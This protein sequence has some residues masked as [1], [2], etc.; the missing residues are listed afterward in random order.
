MPHGE[1]TLDEQTR[2]SQEVIDLLRKLSIV[3]N[4]AASPR[5]T[6]YAALDVIGRHMGWLL[7]RVQ[8]QPIGI[9]DEDLTVIWFN[10]SLVSESP[11]SEEWPEMPL[12]KGPNGRPIFIEDLNTD[13][14]WG[15]A[16]PPCDPPLRGYVAF[17]VQVATQWAGVMEF[18]CDHSTHI[19]LELKQVLGHAA[20]L[21]GLV[22]E[23][24]RAQTLMRNSERRFRAIFEQSYQLISLMEPDGTLIEVN[25]TA[26][27]F[28][29]LNPEEVLGCKIWDTYWWQNSTLNQE[30]LQLAVTR[31]AR[32]DPVHYLVDIQGQAGQT[33]TI[34]FSIKSIRNQRG[35]IVLLMS[36]GRD[37]SELRRTLES[38]RLTEARLEEAQRLAQ[39]GHWEYDMAREE[40][41]WS[42]TLYPV[43]GLDPATTTDP[44]TEFMAR[45]HPDDVAEVRAVMQRAFEQRASYEHTYRLVHP[46]SSIHSVY[47]A[48]NFVAD[49]TGKVVR[50]A[51]IVQDLTGLRRLE[52]SL[53]RSVER[54]SHINTMGQAVASSLD[55]DQIIEQVMAAA[56]SLLGADLVV[57][58]VHDRGRLEIRAKDQRLD[59]D[60]HGLS[61]PDNI[62]IA[63]EVWTTGRALWLTGA[64]CHRRRAA[65]LVQMTGYE[66]EAVIAVP[67]RWQGEL[68][69]VLEAAAR[70][71][72]AFVEDDLDALQAVA[73]WTAIA[74]GKARQHMA[75]ERRLH[76]SE[77]IAEVSRA[78]SETLEPQSILDLIAAIAHRI[79]P[80][81]DWAVIHLLRGRPERLYPVASAG[82]VPPAEN[83]IIAPD[84]GLA[85]RALV[86]GE[87][88][89]TGDA[90]FDPRASQFARQMGMHSLVVAPMQSRN[91]VLG[92]VSIVGREANIFTADDERLMTILAAQ[93]ALAIEN[94]QLY[95]SQRRARSVAEMQRERLR[96]L[97]QRIVTTQED[98][99]LR[100]SRELHD[101]AG[102]ALTSLKISLDLIRAGLPAEQEALR[103]RLA[104]VAGLADQTMETLRTLAHD[105]RPPGLDAFGLNVALEG[106]CYD[107]SIRTNLPIH[108][109]GVE[110]PELP[111]TVALSMYRLV[112]EAL[113]NIVK[114][115]E[116]RQT[117]VILRRENGGLSLVVADDGK[118]FALEPEPQTTRGRG[119]IG[120]I[121]MH[122]RAELL[123]GTLEIDTAPGGGTRLTARIPLE[124]KTIEDSAP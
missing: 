38:L 26:L 84:E 46:D 45:V 60:V 3:A 85:G 77:A 47:S 32:G 109:Q 92:T 123:G 40:A 89:S 1:T 24:G 17:P 90:E 28:A 52:E 70:H 103:A 88:A 66:P 100:I 69:G 99:R 49:E 65:Q 58:F 41:Y 76:E 72:D 117:D 61:I 119:G 73:T 25:Q 54:L 68:L 19:S 91:R 87:V 39:M 97:T 22:V 102:Q 118:G 96:D 78:L 98:E 79:V 83:Y 80:R 121:S 124:A 114:H 53:A 108:Y 59:L 13:E 71:Q 81:T 75:L 110:L 82:N 48:G 27:Q 8:I 106:L 111:T 42:D 62:G 14:A 29:G 94:A 55:L 30:E 101:E 56:R 112:Q 11:C 20:T 107:Y 74:I 21:I 116:A 93:A 9:A 120:L 43:F 104:D 7:G 31:A 113:T 12:A 115:A 105:L 5:T 35:D 15:A 23:R 51:G 95:D 44:G 64:E 6:L 57:L 37:V 33:I 4:E 36:E 18:Y 63:G 16:A 34:F 86:E 2:A 50:V 67:V 122:E 10:R